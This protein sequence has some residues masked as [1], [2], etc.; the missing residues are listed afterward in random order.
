MLAALGVGVAA[1][2]HSNPWL[3]PIALA[4]LLLINRSLSVPALQLEAR[5][6]PKTGLFNTR[7]FA[8]TLEE[9]LTRAQRF[10]RPLSLM[11][12][13]LDLLR[14][15]N[16]RF[17][18]LA[19]DAVLRGVAD[20]LR[21]ELRQY[22]IPARF[23]GEEFSIVLPET[24]SEQALEIAERIRR[25]MAASRFEVETSPGP[26]SATISIGVAS[27]PAD[28]EG[29]EELIHQAD[30]AVYSAKLQGRNRTV[31]A[32][33]ESLL[34]R[35]PAARRSA[36]FRCDG[37]DRAQE[38]HVLVASPVIV[39]R[40]EPAVRAAPISVRLAVFGAFVSVAGLAAGVAGMLL[41]SSVDLLAMLVLLVLVVA[42]RALD[43]EADERAISVSAVGVLAGAALF[44]ATTAL[45][46]ALA[47][48]VV[49][50]SARGTPL[51]RALFDAGT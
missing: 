16:N 35:R 46:L 21:G 3:I 34:A 12:L 39:P 24:S 25:S 38:T 30:L 26:I 14:D 31:A 49:D 27:Y 9:E 13:D 33:A 43:L 6:D 18:H 40:R 42:G 23:G 28:G 48:V 4:P 19:G 45:P 44:G 5:V 41:G 15:V 22:D 2:W 50:W 51:R 36:S 32:S 29:A 47:I 8:A 1:F 11:M 37:E 7:H 17:G 20:V 10:G